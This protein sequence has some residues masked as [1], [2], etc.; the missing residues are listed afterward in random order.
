MTYP[1]YRVVSVLSLLIVAG[2]A[3]LWLKQS[4]PP[5]LQNPTAVN[6]YH[7]DV[8]A[9]QLRQAM[10]SDNVDNQR[11]PLFTPDRKPFV[12][13]LPPPPIPTP[14]PIAVVEDSTTLPP[15]PVPVVKIPEVTTTVAPPPRIEDS[16]ISLVGIMVNGNE[17]RTLLKSPQD[18]AGRWIKSGE[19][20]DGWE[21][22]S[23]EKALVVLRSG[24]TLAKLR[25]YKD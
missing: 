22:V 1:F 16:G 15:P 18:P 23:I 24:P 2:F 13:A 5:A 8:G 20:I 17:T 14:P 6:E 12:P 3:W 10:K 4:S 11:R 25:L 19:I 21:V 9:L 7:F